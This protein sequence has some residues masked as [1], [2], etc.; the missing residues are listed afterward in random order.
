MKF[1]DNI[2]QLKKYWQIIYAVLLIL[3]IP[4]AIIGNTVWVVLSFKDNI[5]LQLQ[6]QALGIAEIFNATLEEELGDEER[7]QHA[8]ERIAAQ[9][10]DV[11]L[12]DIMVP[13]G[14]Y[15]NVVASLT[16]GNI[17][18]TS[19]D[20][21]NVLAWYQGRAIA[22]LT[23]AARLTR[24]DPFATRRF[25]DLQE[26]FWSVTVPLFDEEGNKK[27][28]L[29]LQMS[30]SLVDSVVSQTVFRSFFILSFAVII[31]VLL[32]VANTR[33]FQYAVLAK[34]LKEVEQLKDEFISM[35]SHELRTPITSLRGYLSM[36]AEGSLGALT[37]LAQ[38]KVVMMAGSADRLNELVEDLLNVSRIEQ[39]RLSM[40]LEI[41]DL[42]PI[43]KGVMAELDVQ[44]KQ[45]NL[46]FVYQ[47]PTE[48]L[49]Q[50]LL[51][52]NRLKQVL[53]NIFGNAVKYTP[54][55]SVVVTT[56]LREDNLVEIK[57]ADTGLGMTAKEREK[58]FTKF[59]RVKNKDTDAIKGTGLGLW[60]TKQLIEMMEGEVL[61]DSIKGVGTQ[62]T[63]LFPVKTAEAMQKSL[64]K[65]SER[66]KIEA[67][68]LNTTRV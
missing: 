34:K 57:C 2:L 43:V 47:E 29:S 10:G 4:T 66:I 60:I 42:A 26:R 46:Q 6:R 64:A 14:E 30:L 44:A 7:L 17:G 18:K 19:K 51:D 3:L 49:P 53:I 31:V 56:V 36:L 37:P 54:K 25:E 58:L 55:G 21:A 20:L 52:S 8:L 33:L 23:N 68:S 35:A 24:D 39:G 32:L 65:Q 1:K 28:L 22:N 13:E 45:K 48:P 11:K 5:D 40:N 9:E 15:F 50:L 27:A 12:A 62:M 16:P 67:Q 59:Y 61:V 41:V 63:I 38:E